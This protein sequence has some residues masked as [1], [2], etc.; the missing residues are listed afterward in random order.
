[1]EAEDT[2]SDSQPEG[3]KT[4]TEE[5][6]EELLRRA[7]PNQGDSKSIKRRGTKRRRLSRSTSITTDQASQR[8]GSPKKTPYL[9]PSKIADIFDRDISSKNL[10]K[11]SALKWVSPEAIIKVMPEASVDQICQMCD[12]WEEQISPNRELKAKQRKVSSSRRTRVKQKKSRRRARS[13]SSVPV[14]DR[15]EEVKVETEPKE[16]SLF[17]GGF[18]VPSP[19]EG[20]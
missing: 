15:M 17:N 20:K 5:E 11:L 4:T 6:L 16:L 14:L 13:T 1:M 9:S 10:C 8:E 7:R 18:P 3:P 12:L 19:V 2:A